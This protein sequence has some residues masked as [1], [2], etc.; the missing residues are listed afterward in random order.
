M[1]VW[2]GKQTSQTFHQ[3]NFGRYQETWGLVIVHVHQVIA[4]FGEQPQEMLQLDKLKV[5]NISLGRN[6]PQTDVEEIELSL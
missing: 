2:L 3:S 4:C 6:T 5:R 1:L